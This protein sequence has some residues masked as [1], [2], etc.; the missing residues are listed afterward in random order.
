[1]THRRDGIVKR[2]AKANKIA[3]LV[4]VVEA[5]ELKLMGLEEAAKKAVD[6]F[7][8]WNANASR[9]SRKAE[10]ET[11]KAEHKALVESL[12]R[13]RDELN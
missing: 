9:L 3:K 1:M 10:L 5:D 4:P 6:A 2:R 7:D 8:A 12:T 13:F 11:T